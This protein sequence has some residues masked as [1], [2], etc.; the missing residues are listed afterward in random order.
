M[1]MKFSDKIMLPCFQESEIPL[2][3]NC[4][5]LILRIYGLQVQGIPSRRLLYKEV[6]EALSNYKKSNFWW[7]GNPACGDLTG[8]NQIEKD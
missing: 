6:V 7:F 2:G 5:N 3:L 8:S 4:K 1:G